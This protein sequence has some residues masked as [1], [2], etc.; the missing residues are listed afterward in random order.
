[1]ST[2]FLVLLSVLEL[3]LIGLVL[4]FFGRLKRSEG[5]MQ[6][7]QQ[8]QKDL[9]TKLHFNTELEQELVASFAERQAEL[10]KLEEQL[11]AR[12]AALKDLLARA[13]EMSR[14]PELMRRMILEGHR[15]GKKVGELARAT[16][17]SR[18]EVEL[19]LMQAG[20]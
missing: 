12:E 3:V 4:V 15:Q 17:L 8:S 19:I 18:D 1:M 20:T 13:E 10:G 11:A 6:A 14:S 16:G 2:W 9:L 7:L 5:A